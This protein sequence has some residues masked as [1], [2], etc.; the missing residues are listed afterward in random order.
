MLPKLNFKFAAIP[1]DATE[2]AQVEAIKSA[3]LPGQRHL[4][5]GR[6][7]TKQITVEI[8]PNSQFASVLEMDLPAQEH[9]THK[10]AVTELQGA[11]RKLVRLVTAKKNKNDILLFTHVDP[12]IVNQ[13]L[14]SVPNYSAFLPTANA[15]AGWISTVYLNYDQ[16][17]NWKLPTTYDPFEL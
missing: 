12:Q 6:T 10:I 9:A 11:L 14:D 3:M 13:A 8:T 4:A 15:E 17:L 1:E 7:R 2:D 5:L 16:H